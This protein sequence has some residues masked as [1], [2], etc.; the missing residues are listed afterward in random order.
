MAELKPSQRDSLAL[1]HQARRTHN[2]HERDE[3]GRFTDNGGTRQETVWSTLHKK[4]VPLNFLGV[5]LLQ[6]SQTTP[7]DSGVIHWDCQSVDINQLIRILSLLIHP[8]TFEPL[9]ARSHKAVKQ[10]PLFQQPGVKL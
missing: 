3:S 10:L 5:H 8:V 2:P 9:S 4:Y 1:L 7:L 6:M